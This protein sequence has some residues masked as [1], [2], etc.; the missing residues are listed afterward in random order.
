MGVF[1]SGPSPIPIESPPGLRHQIRQPKMARTFPVHVEVT[2]AGQRRLP[3][4]QGVDRQIRCRHV[5]HPGLDHVTC[6][7]LQTGE[8]SGVVPHEGQELL[9]VPLVRSA[10]FHSS[11]QAFDSAGVVRKSLVYALI[12][13]LTESSDKA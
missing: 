9:Q 1:P 10:T 11:A 13:M 7:V 5:V 4:P 6:E 3:G 2:E 8:P 12:S